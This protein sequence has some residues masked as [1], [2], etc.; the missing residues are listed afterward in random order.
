MNLA[1]VELVEVS[2]INTENEDEG[3][4]KLKYQRD[5]LVSLFKNQLVVMSTR[6]A[7]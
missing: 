7:S 4:Y 2:E 6:E 3:D 5:L 1:K